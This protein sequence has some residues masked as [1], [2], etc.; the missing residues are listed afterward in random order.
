MLS[1]LRQV[2]SP[3]YILLTATAEEEE[4]EEEVAAAVSP[5]THEFVATQTIGRY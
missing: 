3:A 1:E 5:I 4:Q 2:V